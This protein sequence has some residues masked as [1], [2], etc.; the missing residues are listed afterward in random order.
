MKKRPT[1]VCATCGIEGELGWCGR[2]RSVAYCCK[3][4]MESDAIRHLPECKQRRSEMLVLK[5]RVKE[6][7]KML[8]EGAEC[9][10]DQP[11]KAVGTLC[12]ICLETMDSEAAVL[13]L[14]CG[15]SYH[16]KCI[17]ALRA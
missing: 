14:L 3:E 9:R 5:A 13:S 16:P 6:H 15:H 1:M 7:K 10:A 8:R 11:I 17:R 12:V 4:C 2:C